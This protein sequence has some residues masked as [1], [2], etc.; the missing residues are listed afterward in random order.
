MRRD[1]LRL[2]RVHDPVISEKYF[3]FRLAASAGNA[4]S[5]AAEDGVQSAHDCFGICV[6]QELNLTHLRNP[7]L[8]SKIELYAKKVRLTF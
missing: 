4:S 1:L 7:V 8:R 6:L 2:D 3:V 5:F